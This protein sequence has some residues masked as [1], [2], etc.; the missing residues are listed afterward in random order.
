MT[1]VDNIKRHTGAA[2]GKGHIGFAHTLRGFARL[3]GPVN[4][5]SP[6][7]VIAVILTLAG[8]A[9]VG[10]T[11]ATLTGVAPFELSRQGLLVL[12]AVNATIIL[13]IE[14]SSKIMNR[15][16]ALF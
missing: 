7:A 9:C 16:S 14:L 4:Y 11:Y 12:V 10:L 2:G 6:I 3:I 8:A 5:A 15:R 1:T 13:A